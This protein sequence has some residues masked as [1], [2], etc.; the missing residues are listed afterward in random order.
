MH[1]PKIFP[2]PKVIDRKVSK[3]SSEDNVSKPISKKK[4]QTRKSLDDLYLK[5]G[6]TSARRGKPAAKYE[7]RPRQKSN[8]TKVNSFAENESSL[9]SKVNQDIVNKILS[10]LL[11]DTSEKNEKAKAKDLI[12]TTGGASRI[13]KEK[14]KPLDSASLVQNT[15]GHTLLSNV[16][17]ASPV[18][19]D[20]EEAFPHRDIKPDKKH[21]ENQKTEEDAELHEAELFIDKNRTGKEK[22]AFLNNEISLQPKIN[23]MKNKKRLVKLPVLLAK[24]IFDIDI[25][26][27]IQP[28]IPIERITNI[29]WSLQSVISRV[30]L[31]ANTVHFKGVLLADIEYVSEHSNTIHT[32]KIPFVWDKAVRVD[33]LTPPEKGCSSRKEYTFH[34]Y[35]Q[36]FCTHHEFSQAFT[37]EIEDDFRSI[38]FIWHNSLDAHSHSSDFTIQGTVAISINLLQKQYISI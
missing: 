38:R 13:K 4:K 6:S 12:R 24:A 16:E 33:W 30:I 5:Y 37:E 22:N 17:K 9:N 10:M 1:N 26:L 34:S 3:L 15:A 35:A 28:K 18:F 20:D 31:S 25:N 19:L 7:A 23:S 14:T 36:D 11:E 8:R 29:E 21:S 2:P 27:S 32:H